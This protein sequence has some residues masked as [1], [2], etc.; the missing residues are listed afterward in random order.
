MELAQIIRVV[1]NRP[2]VKLVIQLY[3]KNGPLDL[4]D[5]VCAP[6][7]SVQ[8]IYA[9]PETNPIGDTQV[10]CPQDK[11]NQQYINMERYILGSIE[12]KNTKVGELLEF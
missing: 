7:G 3:Q 12:D 5:L 9:V 8:K 4:L 2:R 1:R 10:V 6:C 11:C